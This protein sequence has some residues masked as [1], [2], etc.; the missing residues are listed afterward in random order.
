MLLERAGAKLYRGPLG[1]G[2]GEA[3]CQM[4]D[5]FGNLLGLIGTRGGAHDEGR[6]G[7]T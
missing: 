5:S 3:I 2:N 6:T 1:M 7:G 4:L